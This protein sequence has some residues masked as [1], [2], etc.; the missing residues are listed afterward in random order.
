[1]KLVTTIAIG[2]LL[3]FSSYSQ[4]QQRGSEGRRGPQLTA[5]QRTCLEE[6]IGNPGQGDRPS[7]EKMEA[8]MSTC[9]IEKPA[10]PAGRNRTGRYDEAGGGGSR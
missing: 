10:M 7:R 8:A 2:A 1:M 6:I 3:I 5:E 4:A 9:G